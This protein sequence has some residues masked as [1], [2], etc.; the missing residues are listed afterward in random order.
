M[1]N[2]NETLEIV[3]WMDGT[4]I[5][6]ADNVQIALAA[7]R[8]AI[9]LYPVADIMLRHRARIIARHCQKQEP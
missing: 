2:S 5:A 9:K 6:R 1:A 8:E 3:V 4:V 7:Y